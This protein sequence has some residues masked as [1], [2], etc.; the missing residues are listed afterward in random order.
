LCLG[1]LSLFWLEWH[2]ISLSGASLARSGSVSSLELVDAQPDRIEQRNPNFNAFTMVLVDQAR[3]S[4]RCAE[5][6]PA[7]GYCGNGSPP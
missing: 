4:A 7:V 1:F 3:E 5:S 2:I 6:C